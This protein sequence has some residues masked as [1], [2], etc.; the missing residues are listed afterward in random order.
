MLLASTL[1]MNW[2]IIIIITITDNKLCLTLGK[3]D[4]A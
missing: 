2:I 3:S 4:L 1:K